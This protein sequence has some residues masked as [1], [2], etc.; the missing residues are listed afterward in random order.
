MNKENKTPLRGFS[1]YPKEFVPRGPRS[2][3]GAQAKPDAPADLPDADR[4]GR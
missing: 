4:R 3:L 2:S 1:P